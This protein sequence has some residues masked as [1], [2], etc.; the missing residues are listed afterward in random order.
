[1]IPKSNSISKQGA[2]STASQLQLVSASSTTDKIGPTS[3]HSSSSISIDASKPYFLRAECLSATDWT[4]LIDT[5]YE[6]S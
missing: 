3:N 5:S 1:M 2:E 6:N 4:R